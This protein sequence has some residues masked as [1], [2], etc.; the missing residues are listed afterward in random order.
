[1]SK[2]HLQGKLEPNNSGSV[3]FFIGQ[4]LTLKKLLK[5]AK[6]HKHEKV[7]AKELMDELVK[8]DKEERA[9][10]ATFWLM[11]LNEKSKRNRRYQTNVTT[12]LF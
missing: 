2:E 8:L 10:L 12:Y 6:E 1:M 7:S 3:F 4:C 5:E 11:Q 9:G